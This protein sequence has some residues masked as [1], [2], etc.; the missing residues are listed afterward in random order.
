MG[1]GNKR[2]VVKFLTTLL[3]IRFH[4]YW[5]HTGFSFYW[6]NSSTTSSVVKTLLEIILKLVKA[7][8]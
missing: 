3:L 5:P 7:A 8:S 4:S 2:G 1:N 6:F